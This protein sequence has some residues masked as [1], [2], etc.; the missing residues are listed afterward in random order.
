[1][2]LSCRVSPVVRQL[3][4]IIIATFITAAAAAI[5]TTIYV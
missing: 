2:L 5:T 1:L 3:I 4:C